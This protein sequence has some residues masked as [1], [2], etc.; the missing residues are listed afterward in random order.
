M[1]KMN[2]EKQPQKK[3]IVT[4]LGVKGAPLTLG[5]A[6]EKVRLLLRKV[7]PLAPQSRKHR[8]SLGR[9]RQTRVPP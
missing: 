8:T 5:E 6:Q 9:Q 3:M 7:D 2:I 4:I 1:S